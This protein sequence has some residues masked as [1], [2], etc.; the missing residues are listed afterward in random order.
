LAR[1]K[2]AEAAIVH[3]LRN[4]STITKLQKHGG[5]E[6]TSEVRSAVRPIQAGT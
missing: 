3:I 2:N 1:V 6:A 4:P 5:T